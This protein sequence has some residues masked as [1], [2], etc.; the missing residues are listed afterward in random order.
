MSKYD[1]EIQKISQRDKNK[2][3]SFLTG[4]KNGE[5]YLWEMRQIISR[6]KDKLWENSLLVGSIHADQNYLKICTE[7]LEDWEEKAE[8]A[9]QYWEDHAKGLTPEE[10]DGDDF[11]KSSIELISKSI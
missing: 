2:I 5:N 10:I 6:L 9:L 1:Y 8:I 4:D 3:Q 7:E 11:D